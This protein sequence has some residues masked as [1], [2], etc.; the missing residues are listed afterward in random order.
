MKVV[1][2][3]TV[4]IIFLNGIRVDFTDFLFY[5][6]L[7]RSN[8]FILDRLL[9]CEFHFMT[10]NKTTETKKS[11]TA[12]INAVPDEQKRKDSFKVI[13]LMKKK[14]GHEPKMWGPSIVGF[15]SYHYKYESGREGDM[16]VVAFSP[17]KPAIV[18]YLSGNYDKREKLLQ[19]LGKYKTGKGCIYVRK[20]ADVNEKILTEMISES[21]SH[22]KKH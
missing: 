20:L 10:K 9:I 13:E 8:P 19:Q 18:F 17:R 21:L 1:N 15:G 4:R 16:P 5:F 12:F 3:V 22:M 7:P 14:S 6:T 2:P 11:V